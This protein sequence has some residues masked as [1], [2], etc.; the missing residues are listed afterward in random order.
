MAH[1]WCIQGHWRLF[2]FLVRPHLSLTAAQFALLK[3]LSENP[4]NIVI[5]LVRDK[6]TTDKKIADEI[7]NRS[8]IHIFQADLLSFDDLKASSLRLRNT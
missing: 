6:A 7:G 4:E 1:Y 3:N 5:G 8:N 2:I